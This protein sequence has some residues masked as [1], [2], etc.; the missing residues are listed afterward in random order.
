V[1]SGGTVTIEGINEFRAAV[2][3]A[4]GAA[5][6]EIP[7]ALKRA[8]APILVQAASNAPHRTGRLAAG[9]KVAVKG[10]TAS[11]V[12]TVPYAGGAE[13]GVHGKW[14]GFEGAPPRYVWPAVEAQEASV[15]LIIE[16]ELRDIIGIYGWAV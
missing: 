3:K 6:R 9:Y 15:E 12:S 14:A 13:W 4:A 7:L 1:A 16:N 5:P 8:G 10:T 2:R 11:I